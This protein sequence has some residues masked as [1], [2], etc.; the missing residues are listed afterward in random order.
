MHQ[1]NSNFLQKW[2]NLNTHL[3]DLLIVPQ[4][5]T[6]TITTTTTTTTPRSSSSD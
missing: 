2:L 3:W 4:K 6:T 1:S 5:P